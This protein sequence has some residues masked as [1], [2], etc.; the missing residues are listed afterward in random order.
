V[1]KTLIFLEN[2]LSI[3]ARVITV[4]IINL[5]FTQFTGFNKQ[6]IFH[7]KDRAVK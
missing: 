3:Y 1:G 7:D 6:T 2:E 5:T 4:D